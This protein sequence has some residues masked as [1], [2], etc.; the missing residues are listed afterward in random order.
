MII[1]A[2]H[3]GSVPIKVGYLSTNTPILRS[4]DIEID[5]LITNGQKESENAIIEF[6]RA[7]LK[8]KKIDK[9]EI[10]HLSETHKLWEVIKSGMSVQSKA[11]YK[12][13]IE[14]FS[15][16]RDSETGEQII[17]HKPKTKRKLRRADRIL[18]KHFDENVE[19][20]EITSPDDIDFFIKNA[21]IICK[22][23]YLCELGVGI[24]DNEY[25]KKSLTDMALGGY[26]RGYLIIANSLPIS[27]SFGLAYKNT[28]YLF[29]TA[30]N[31][32]YR[33]ISPGGFLIRR[34]LEILVEA[35]IDHFHFGFGDAE[36]KRLYGNESNTEA[37][38]RIYGFTNK[39]R[40]SKILDLTTV[41]VHESVM[42]ALE[43]TGYLN[44]I[45]KFWRSK[46]SKK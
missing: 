26:F 24:E 46:L 44:K 36:Y 25:W 12:P 15:Q 2:T 34:M 39:A 29:A 9:L 40:I 19:V 38:F 20:K 16:I 23:S 45:K 8:Q 33:D 1:G 28:F 41:T 3:E 10:M 35:K 31:S 4:L 13:G 42:G 43:K 18:T 22:K 11:I 14:W 17:H 30:F 6:L 21:D 32:D 27:Y 5:G 37:S 7:L